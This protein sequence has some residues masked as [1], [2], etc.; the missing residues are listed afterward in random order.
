MKRL[1]VFFGLLLFASP[2]HATIAVYPSLAAAP[3]TTATNYRA[4]LSGTGSFNSTESNRYQLA[5]IE[6]TYIKLSVVLDTAP[7][8]GAGT[9]SYTFTVRSGVSDTAT[10][11]TIS[12]SATSC[13]STT[14][15]SMGVGD[16]ISLSCAPS[17]SAPAAS[18]LTFSIAIAS[19]T[20]GQSSI[21][22]GTGTVNIATG[23]TNYISPHTV[24]TPTTTEK[25]VE[26]LIPTSGTF[27]G[28]RVRLSGSP[29]NGGGT[30]TY[31]FTVRRGVGTGAMADTS[32]TCAISETA[33]TCNDLS[34]SFTVAAG[35]RITISSAP[36]A[37]TPTARLAW[38]GLIFTSDVDGEFIVPFETD[39][40]PSTV[41]VNYDPADGSGS[42]WTATETAVDQHVGYPFTVTAIY[43]NV[44]VAP[45]LGVGVQSYDYTLR[46]NDTTD[47]TATCNMSET[48]T[49]CSLTGLSVS[50]VATDLIDTEATPNVVPTAPTSQSISY[51]GFITPRRI[52]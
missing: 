47:T 11:C 27:S 28:L 51:L 39:N 20:V 1:L 12:E 23:A 10:T 16:R 3:S 32:V 38:F 6:G 52:W 31:T 48:N 4:L 5:G 44:D 41:A 8:N 21:S 43:V 14:E 15:S 50:L 45:D 42:T 40:A 26:M 33:T 36:T 34:N 37:G 18:A 2:A 19:T 17:A 7:E 29:N 35:D 25:F 30:Q 46:T 22:A 9:Q 24:S 49:T 13:T